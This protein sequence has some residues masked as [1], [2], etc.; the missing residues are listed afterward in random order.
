[1]PTG[2]MLCD[3]AESRKPRVPVPAAN[4]VALGKLFNLSS[5]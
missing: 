4:Y 2:V 1:M 5:A 3:V